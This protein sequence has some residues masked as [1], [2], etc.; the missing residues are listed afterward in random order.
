MKSQSN[1]ALRDKMRE[2]ISSDIE[3]FLKKGGQIEKVD[4]GVSSGQQYTYGN[5]N[6][7][8]TS[9]SSKS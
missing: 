1:I 4:K 7:P 3:E 8:T 9:T 2:K 5:Q 6:K